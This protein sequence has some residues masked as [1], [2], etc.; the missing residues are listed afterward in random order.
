MV[1]AMELARLIDGLSDPAA[2]PGPVGAVEVRQ[3]HI[4]AVFLVGDYVYKIKKSVNYGFVDFDTLAKRRHY[5]DEEVRLNRRL[6]PDVYLGVVPVTRRDTQL[7]LEGNGEVVEW[8]VK[9]R[10]LPEEATLQ[11]WLQQGKVGDEV[12]G[13][14]ARRIAAFHAQ[15]E[16]GERIAT[17]GRFP[18]VAKNA[19]E[20]FEHSAVQVGT[21]V[22]K[23]VFQRA[24]T[25]TEE[26]L[27][28]HQALIDRRAE[29]NIPRD[30]HGD[31]RLGH[32]YYFPNRDPPGDLVVIDCI[33]FNERFRFA[34][35]VSD[36]AFL[37]MGLVYQGRRDLADAFAKAYYSS[38]QDNEGRVLLPLY[39]SYR[40]AVRGKVEGLKLARPEMSESDRTVALSK[41]KGSWLVALGELEAPSRK[42]C[43]ILVGGLPGTGKSTLANALAQP[44]NFRVIRS[45][46]VR[47]ELAGVG[48]VECRSEF[49]QGIYT[50]E[51]TKLTYADCL[52][53]AEELL[54]HGERV[55]VDA[56]FRE[57]NQRRMF[58]DAAIRWG[59]PTVFFL[60]ETEPELLLIRLA[61]RRGDASDADWSVYENAVTTW[62]ELGPQTRSRLQTINTGE[63]LASALHNTQSVL[64]KQGLYGSKDDCHECGS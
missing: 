18:V 52:R 33:E 62:E 42:P 61:N 34:D 19:R 22:S 59:V 9:M 14:L 38:S 28:L 53:Q 41:A 47:K 2:Y 56:N 16:S 43:L 55:L 10:R 39:T 50:A 15:A 46:V 37:Y 44:A 12:I 32:V 20:N 60:C 4:S 45:D 49:G 58:L 40:A 6:A 51:W 48:G 13:R 30:T 64:R 54:F 29:H 21:T 11:N 7:E 23:S 3:T 57:D 31:L 1:A 63:A 8:A 35:P 17:Y 5:C 36:M 24:R 25:L 27:A 26:A